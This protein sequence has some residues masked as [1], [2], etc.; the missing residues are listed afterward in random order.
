M[1]RRCPQRNHV[2]MGRRCTNLSKKILNPDGET[3]AY[4]IH[5]LEGAC[6]MAAEGAEST[7][8]AETTEELLS[9]SILMQP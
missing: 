5:T 6:G 3:N 1:V 7:Q 4:C 9:M 8:G 2:Q